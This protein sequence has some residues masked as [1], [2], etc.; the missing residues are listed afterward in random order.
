MGHDRQQVFTPY[1]EALH[2]ILM[3][4]EL[5]VSGEQKAVFKYGR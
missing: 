2:P 1:N 4:M 5:Y 3:E